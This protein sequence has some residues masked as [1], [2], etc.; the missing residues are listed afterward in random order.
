VASDRSGD[1]AVIDEGGGANPT[2]SC[3]WQELMGFANK[4][5]E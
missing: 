5:S 1:A 4:D 3:Q 2:D